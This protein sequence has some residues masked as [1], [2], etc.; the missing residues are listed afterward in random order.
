MD[1]V[2]SH[3]GSASR[4]PV[5]ARDA[6]GPRHDAAGSFADRSDKSEPG[7]DSFQETVPADEE[8][9]EEEERTEGDRQEEELIRK[10]GLW[11]D[12]GAARLLD[13][14]FYQLEPCMERKEV[15][16]DFACL[17]TDIPFAS[18]CTNG[19]VFISRGLYRRLRRE[20]TLFYC[21]H[22]LAHTELRHYAT[23]RRRLSE[24]RFAFSAPCGS[25]VRLRLDQ[26]AVLSVRHQEEFEADALASEWLGAKSASEAL[27]KLHQICLAEFPAGLTRPTHPPFEKRLQHVREGLPFPP[28]MQ[29]LHTLL[30]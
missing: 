13:S 14:C 22:E 24:V 7:S 18:S 30:V 25:P 8:L 16:Y 5:Q 12:E 2:R 6:A 23:R 10:Y 19:C 9:S 17:D 1:S 27:D 29:Y 3:S 11:Q 4:A 26:A 20:D 15:D 21:A 28:L